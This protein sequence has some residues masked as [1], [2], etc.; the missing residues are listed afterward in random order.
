MATFS[1]PLSGSLTKLPLNAITGSDGVVAMLGGWF[2]NIRV[3]PRGPAAD[4]RTV[5]VSEAIV[6]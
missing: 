4:A 3:G 5:P 6:P 1:A 2:Q